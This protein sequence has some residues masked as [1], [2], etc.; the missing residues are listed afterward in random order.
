[1]ALRGT[2]AL[3]AIV[4]GSV[5]CGSPEPP[6]P[7]MCEPAIADGALAPP[8]GARPG[9]PYRWLSRSWR[10]PLGLT[11]RV[12]GLAIDGVPVTGVHQVEIDDARGQL[13]HRAGTGDA[14]LAEL[15]ARG[16]AAWAAWRHPLASLGA[17]A[18]RPH[19]AAHTTQRA[20]WHHAGGAVVPAVRTERVNLLDD[21]PVAEIIVRDAT[22]GA[23]LARHGTLHELGDPAYLVYAGDDGRPL[24]S[25]LGS[26][27]RHPTGVP[28]GRVPAAVAQQLRR[29]SEAVAALPDPWV[30]ASGEQTNGNNVIAFFNS[31]LDARGQ[32]A[33]LQD[34]LG[35]NT[36]EYGPAPGRDDFFATATAGSFAFRYDP[37]RTASEYFQDG[38]PGTAAAR[39][40]A[41]DVALNAKIV[42]AFYATNWLHDYFYG[43]GFDEAA[44][45]AQQSNFGR[46]GAD[47]DPLIVHSGFYTTFTFVSPEGESPILELGLNARSASRRDASVDFTIVAHEWGHTMIG[48]L[49]GATANPEALFGLQGQALHEGIADFVSLLVNLTGIDGLGA[50]AVG[51]YMNLDYIELR[52]TL[53]AAEAPADAMYYGIRRY[54]YSLDFHKNPL[55]FRHLAEPPPGD[56]P[57]YNWKG[58]GP[59]LSEP[60]TT[61][62]V[63]AE[64]LL[65]CFSNIVAAHPGSAGA[66]FEAMRARMAQYLV[67]GLAAF[68]DH[69]SLLDARNALLTVIRLVSPTQDYPACRAGF[70]ARGMGAD[71][72]GP[73]RG[74]ALA[75]PLPRYDPAQVAE[76]FLDRDRAAR[77]SSSFTADATGGTIGV[78]LRNSGLIDVASS[79]EITPAVP[80]AAVFPGGAR[81]D[82]ARLAPEQS[83]A[84]AFAVTLD[85]CLL[86]PHPTQ[87]GFQL[88]DY[89]VTATAGAEVLR[90]TTYHVAV[91]SPPSACP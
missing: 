79:L 81:A 40:D 37:T 54:P 29:Q 28:D 57:Y 74:I 33:P 8:P 36:P 73:D 51:A 24:P 13:V 35:D 91:P 1:M 49:V 46:G 15:R 87:P 80:A 70:A 44:G 89:T 22:T 66:D 60:H 38:Q 88:F 76:S 32:I 21:P 78:E 18:P 72:L 31:L 50:Y 53:P 47:C 58:R 59:Q 5:A 10:S 82:L 48:R 3:I 19:P 12:F 55:S 64:A 62:E 67:A 9:E 43:A 90:A 84:A 25:P 75:T 7:A 20:V 83:A 23:E 45:N 71:T 16:A 27:I 34:D 63:F 26:A 56:L 2:R 77:L 86:P 85:A 17:G 65:H 68:P 11:I 41:H 14:V 39:P 4:V 61:G 42:A 52:P 30:P 69:P 6:E